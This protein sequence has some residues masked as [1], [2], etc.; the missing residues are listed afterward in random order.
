MLRT[1]AL[2]SVVLGSACLGFAWRDIQSGRAP[3]GR[4]VNRLLG[5]RDNS[6]MAPDKVFRQSYQS[7][8]NGYVHKVS[9]TDLKYAGMQGLVSSLGDPHTIFMPP[10]MASMFKEDTSGK[11]FGVGARLQTDPLGAK[12]AAVFEDGPAYAAGLR[13]NDLIVTVDGKK[14][15]GMVIDAIVDKIKGKEGTY[16]KLTIVRPK[17]NKPIELKIRRARIQTPT[18]ERAYLEKENVGYLS[19]S[20]VSEPTADQFDREL[21][22]LEARGMK[23]LVIDVRGNP[24]GL[25]ETTRDMLGR[26]FENKVVVKMKLRDGQE[27]VVSTYSGGVKETNYPIAILIDENTASAA[28]IFAGCLKDYGKATLV[29]THSYGKSSVQNLFQLK[30]N[31]SAK[32]TIAK[33]FLPSGTDI[34]RKVD[35]D[36]VYVSGGLKPD[37]EVKLDPNVDPMPQDPKTDAQLAKAMEVVLG[38]AVALNDLPLF[39]GPAP[40]NC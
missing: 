12:A 3:D 17:V 20:Q 11:F 30:D 14:V 18:V 10:K 33:Y 35:D 37:F 34:G 8:S 9:A 31:A 1:V 24:G 6:G 27:E 32:V 25:L 23:G 19:I 21:G 38:K 4:A 26:F 39:G 5:V 22:K 15:G 2:G 28:E 7:I 29:G 13:K 40:R 16:V 36:G